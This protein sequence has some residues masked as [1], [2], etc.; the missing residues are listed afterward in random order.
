MAEVS[1][2]NVRKAMVDILPF[3][4]CVGLSV[5]LLA[6]MTCIFTYMDVLKLSIM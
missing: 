6:K 2:K 5:V 4:R 1:A 3:Y